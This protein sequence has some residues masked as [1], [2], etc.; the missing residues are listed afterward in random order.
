MNQK[1]RALIETLKGELEA[2]LDEEQE[3][4]ENLPESFQNSERGEQMQAAIAG[5]P[6][7]MRESPVLMPCLVTTARAGMNRS[8]LPKIHP[9]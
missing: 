2:I 4:F 5:L 7:K 1:R 8:R 9:Q 3:A 6:E